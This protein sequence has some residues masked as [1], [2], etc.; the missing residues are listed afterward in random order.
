VRIR[1][2]E[3]QVDQLESRVSHLEGQLAAMPRR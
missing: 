3:Q 2:L 1:K